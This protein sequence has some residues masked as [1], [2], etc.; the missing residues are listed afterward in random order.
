MSNVLRKKMSVYFLRGKYVGGEEGGGGRSQLPGMALVLS[1]RVCEKRFC[2]VG[3]HMEWCVL[4]NKSVHSLVYSC[5]FFF[6]NRVR[7]RKLGL[8]EHAHAVVDEKFETYCAVR[9]LPVRITRQHSG[10][11]DESVAMVPR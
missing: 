2:Q 6:F 3:R 9:A 7:F 11:E 5:N 8:L 4:V 10:D 1:R